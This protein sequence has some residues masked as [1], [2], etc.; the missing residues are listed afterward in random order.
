V[1][2]VAAHRRDHGLPARNR[3]RHLDRQV[4]RLT[5]ADAEDRARQCATGAVGKPAGQC[6]AVSGHQVVVAHVQLLERAADGLDHLR[7]AV[8]EIENTAVAVDVEPAA[9]VECVAEERP[10]ARAHHQIDAELAKEP[11]LA[12]RD[13]A[14]KGLQGLIPVAERLVFSHV[15]GE[16]TIDPTGRLTDEHSRATLPDRGDTTGG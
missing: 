4:D 14:R 12:R 8:A 9:V 15:G 3:P 1:A 11:R 13:M 10:L 5:A 16:I 2:V 6:R 7:V